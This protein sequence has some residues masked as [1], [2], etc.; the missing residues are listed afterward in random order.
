[1]FSGEFTTTPHAR[2]SPAHSCSQGQFPQESPH[3]VSEQGKQSR[4]WLLTQHHGSRESIRKWGLPGYDRGF[5][6]WGKGEG[7]WN[8]TAARK[9][10]GGRQERLPTSTL[11]T[12]TGG[13]R[14]QS[15]WSA[16]TPT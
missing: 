12:R 11:L 7:L 3:Q 9:N 13:A 10:E 2:L 4:W 8:T 5:S 15:A 16:V 1:M 14:P 6:M